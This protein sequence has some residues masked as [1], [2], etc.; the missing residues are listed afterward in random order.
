LLDE[1]LDDVIE[2]EVFFVSSGFFGHVGGSSDFSSGDGVIEGGGGI[3]VDI[4]ES[5][6]VRFST[7]NGDD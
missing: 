1:E 3:E 6:F 2:D 5:F 4:P 7:N